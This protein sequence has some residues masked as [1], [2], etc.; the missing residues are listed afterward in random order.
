MTANMSSLLTFIAAAH[1][2]V[3]VDIIDS[4]IHHEICLQV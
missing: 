1:K 4:G 2:S 3:S